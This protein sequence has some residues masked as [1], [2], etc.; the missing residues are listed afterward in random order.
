MSAEVAHVKALT[1]IER[2]AEC[3][4]PLARSGMS[5]VES[6]TTAAVFKA[7]SDPG[8]VRI[9]N[10]LANAGG[11][12]CV[13]DLTDEVGLSQPTVSFHLKKLVNAGLVDRKRRGVWAFYSLNRAAL[14]RMGTVF[15]MEGASR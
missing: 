6:E 3:C 5:D 11:P 12:V 2:P 13:C 14:E 7:L 9:V 8:R 10:L 1:L 4:S 15:R